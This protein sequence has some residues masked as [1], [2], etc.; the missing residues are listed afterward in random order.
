MHVVLHFE[1]WRVEETQHE[2]LG[3]SFTYPLLIITDS[4]AVGS[5]HLSKTS[6]IS[7]CPFRHQGPIYAFITLSVLKIEY[8]RPTA[9][10]AA[11]NEKRFCRFLRLATN[12][13]ARAVEWKA[14]ILRVAHFELDNG[15]K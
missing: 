1:R 14:C 2:H 13:A 3:K 9:P 6:I 7:F 15:C 4:V 10:V 11:N 5:C 8:D 12:V